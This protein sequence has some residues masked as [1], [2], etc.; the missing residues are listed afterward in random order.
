MS[1][2]TPAQRPPRPEIEYPEDNGEPLSENTLQFEWIATIKGGL[3]A[4]FRDA[5]KVFVAGDLLWYPVEGDN[6]TRMA[7]D[8]MVVF[9]R[10]K[11]YR[12]SYMQWLEEGVAPQVVFEVL[13]PGNRAGEMIRKF[14]FYDRFGVEEYYIYDPDR[15]ELNGYLRQAGALEE[16]P[17][18][19]GW[20]SPRLGIRF[21]MGG[22]E[23]AILGPDGRPFVSYID[24]ARQRDEAAH[25]RDEAARQR[26]EAARQRDEAAHQRDEE[27]RRAERLAERLRALGVDPGEDS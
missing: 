15:V 9:G 7:P 11:G 2:L 12:G 1:A 21:D 10:P 23:L 19:D 3:D 5:T 18:L 4:L 24:L 25:Q 22:P 6:T 14:R 16:I 20:V 17:T 27:R 8:A 26:D 13:S